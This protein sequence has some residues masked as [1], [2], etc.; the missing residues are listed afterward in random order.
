M[1]QF[2]LVILKTGQNKMTDAEGR[3]K[4]FAGC[5]ASMGRLR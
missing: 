1:R 5:F 4:K 2:V 3:K